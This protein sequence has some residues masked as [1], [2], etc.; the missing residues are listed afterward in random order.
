MGEPTISDVQEKLAIAVE[1][2]RKAEERATTG[3]LALEVMHEIKNPLEAL[4][5][6]TYL[7]D[8]EADDPIKVHEYM[9]LAT[10]QMVI[11]RDIA[12]YTL[13]FAR[14]TPMPKPTRLAL[15][16][17]T[18]LRIHQRTIDSRKIH[19]IKDLPEDLTVSVYPGE[20][21]QVVSNLICN[22]LDALPAT[23]ILRLRTRK[24]GHEIDLVIADNGSGIP[25]QHHQAIFEPFFTTKEE[26]GTGLGLALSRKIVER[27]HGSIRMRSSVRPGKSG[28]VFKIS[29]PA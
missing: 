6:L 22:A 13:G 8:K 27:H 23:G 2:L 29:L 20:M 17:E 9:Q 19:L 11:L 18:G 16:A 21:L 5:H 10:E 4:G 12:S 25:A 15:L 7:A 24:R 3:Q 26:R 28:T 14:S 1:A